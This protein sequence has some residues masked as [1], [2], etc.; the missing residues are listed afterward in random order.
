[1]KFAAF[2]VKEAET[3]GKD[4][5]LEIKTPFDEREVLD[6]NRDF[7]FEN[8]P[9]VKE[10]RVL[11]ATDATEVEGSTN[12]RDAAVPGKPSAFFY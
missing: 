12:A 10:F 4:A 1:V 6:N 8:I 11:E 9:T 5:A 2:V 7:V 3:V